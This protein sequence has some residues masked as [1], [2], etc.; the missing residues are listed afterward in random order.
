M[1]RFGKRFVAHTN[2]KAPFDKLCGIV[3]GLQAEQAYLPTHLSYKFPIF[4][5]LGE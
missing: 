1:A 3:P 2:E 4:D 5:P